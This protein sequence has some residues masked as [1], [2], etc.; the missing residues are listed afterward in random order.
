VI[1]LL[2]SLA[3]LADTIGV[4]ATTNNAYLGLNV[5]YMLI[6]VITFGLCVKAMLISEYNRRTYMLA[7][8]LI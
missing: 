5:L 2:E 1:L 4:I 8:F 6:G 3:T 7:A